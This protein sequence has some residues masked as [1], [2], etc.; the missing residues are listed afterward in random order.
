VARPAR[1]WPALLAA[2]RPQARAG[3]HSQ[4]GGMVTGSRRGWGWEPTTKALATLEALRRAPAGHWRATR[5][6]CKSWWASITVSAIPHGLL[7]QGKK[8]Q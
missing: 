1:G 7:H 6:G 8:P 4:D 5:N 3:A 2:G